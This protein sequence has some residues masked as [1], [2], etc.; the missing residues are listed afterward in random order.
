M[1]ATSQEHMIAEEPLSA[2]DRASAKLRALGVSLRALPGEYLVNIRKGGEATARIA[3]DLD[4]A[5]ALGEALAAA[6]ADLSTRHARCHPLKSAKRYRRRFIRRHN[7][8]FR[9]QAIG[10]RRDH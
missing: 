3:P 6:V 2:F 10:R 8:R 9:R 4:E 5:V 7:K 1:L